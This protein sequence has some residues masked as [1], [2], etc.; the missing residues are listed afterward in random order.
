MAMG[1]WTGVVRIVLPSARSRPHLRFKAYRALPGMAQDPCPR[2]MVPPQAEAEPDV[3]VGHTW[4]P[5]SNTAA[6]FARVSRHITGD[7]RTVVFNEVDC[8]P[9]GEGHPTQT[10]RVLIMEEIPA[11]HHA[12]GACCA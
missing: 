4:A 9:A 10:S 8:M 6:A 2:G 12:L 1:Q 11:E 7:E 5:A 3:G